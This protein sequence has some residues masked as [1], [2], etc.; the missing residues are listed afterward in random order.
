[1]LK[2]HKSDLVKGSPLNDP[3]YM[4]V[5]T[6]IEKHHYGHKSKKL[7]PDFKLQIKLIISAKEF[8]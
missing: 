1:M 8:P 3:N 2:Q 4:Q 7:N 6:W 5:N